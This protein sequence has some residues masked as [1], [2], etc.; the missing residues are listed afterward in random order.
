MLLFMD[1]WASHFEAWDHKY[2]AGKH[3]FT[4]K[5]DVNQGF[6]IF[7]KEYISSLLRAT[8]GVKVAFEAMSPNSVTFTF[9]DTL[10]NMNNNNKP[11][12]NTPRSAS[13]EISI[14]SST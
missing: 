12:N 6:S 4:I 13:K 9:D 5:H 8:A 7:S 3:I 2:E 11:A 1:L 10:R 14:S